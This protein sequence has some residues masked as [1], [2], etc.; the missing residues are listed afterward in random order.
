MDK[1][2]EVI[3]KLCDLIYLKKDKGEILTEVFSELLKLDWYGK[4]G[5]A[6]LILRSPSLSPQMLVNLHFDSSV[7]ELFQKQSNVE[8]IWE[9]TEKLEKQTLI[10]SNELGVG[11]ISKNLSLY[12]PFNGQDGRVGLLIISSSEIEKI[13]Q[14]KKDYL[15]FLVHLIGVFCEFKENFEAK[16]EKLSLT[17]R[18]I[19]TNPLSSA[20][21]HLRS[22]KDS[23]KE[24]NELKSLEEELKKIAGDVRKIEEIDKNEFFF[25]SNLREDVDIDASAKYLASTILDSNRSAI[26]AIDRATRIIVFNK[27]AEKIFGYHEGEML[28]NM[29]LNLIIPP[30]YLEASTEALFNFMMTGVSTGA[31][32]KVLELEGQHKDGRIF[33]IRISFGVSKSEDDIFVIANIEDITLEVQNRKQSLRQEKHAAMGEMMAMIIH[34][35]RQPLSIISGKIQ[36]MNAK[37]KKGVLS[38]EDAEKIL[39]TMNLNV[40]YMTQTMKDFRN[41]FKPSKDQSFFLNEIIDNIENML[42]GVYYEAGIKMNFV[43]KEN[44]KVVGRPNEVLQALINII[45]NAKDIIGEKDPDIKEITI[46]S[47]KEKEFAVLKVM[48]YAGGIPEDITEKIFEPYFSTKQD[49]GTG[50]GLDMVKSI[51]EKSGGQ[52]FA[53]NVNHVIDDIKYTGACFTIKLP[54]CKESN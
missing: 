54:F 9:K 13:D 39:Q 37:N 17:Y 8:I 27:M 21:E 23:D 33:P 30:K 46:E 19:V 2:F 52:I 26:I 35:W 11:E 41:F 14:S 40:D 34:Q 6:F 38:S 1:E 22:L 47:S 16:I 7:S 10:N 51:I 24:N 50:I 4:E 31:I 20:I 45:K 5:S 49:Q 15:N 28:Y 25:L 42:S 3:H 53:S 18:D 12:F 36:L 29:N 48:D 44:V 32:K 43:A